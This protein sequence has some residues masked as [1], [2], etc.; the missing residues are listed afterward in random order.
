[1]KTA[2]RIS[3]SVGIAALLIIGL[4]TWG[5]VSPSDAIDTILQLPP[6]VYLIALGM[7]MTLYCLRA[8]RFNLLIP[9]ERRPS[10][11]RSLIVSGA[12][13]M[14]SYV[15]P[16]KTGEASL[17]V[18]L[19]MQCGVPSAMGLASLMVSRLLD[20][21]TLCLGLSAACLWLAHSGRYDYLEWLG[22]AGLVLIFLCAVFAV[23]SVRGDLLVRVIAWAARWMKLHHFSFGE[24]LLSKANQLAL[25]LRSAGGGGRLYL[26]AFVTIPV[27]LLVFAF[28][29]V[30]SREMGL[31]RHF[32]F[33]EATFGSSLAVMFNLLPVNGMAG[34]GTQELG[35]VTGFSKFLGV[36][37]SIALSAGIGCHAIQLFNVVAIGLV[38]H[39]FMGVMPRLHFD[40][41]EE[42]VP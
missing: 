35:W 16:A 21:A 17:V 31:P 20:G 9:R 40:P 10:F 41:V 36:E 13:N 11:R 32:S 25:A 12:H 8:L 33:A 38:A 6:H 4:M 22:N 39:L 18:Y 30:L 14:A 42:Q 24:G 3:A 29:A 37:E 1:M 23:L 27:W 26:A 7:H 2:T 28:Y 15:L 34:V 5:G 19:R